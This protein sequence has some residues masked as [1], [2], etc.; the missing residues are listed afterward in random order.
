MFSANGESNPGFLKATWNA[1]DDTGAYILVNLEADV[2]TNHIYTFSTSG[3]HAHSIGNHSHSIGNH[4]H[5]IGDHSH[6]VSI[7]DHSHTVSIG[8]HSHNIIYGVYEAP[9]SLGQ[10]NVY[11]DGVLRTSSINSKSIID[12]TSFIQLKGWHQILIT[13]P[14]LNRF[15]ASLIIKSYIGA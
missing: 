11:V 3:N 5:T 10:M 8:N 9:F 2:N 12:L 4:S 15:S 1:V 7:S 14:F 13:S 6:T